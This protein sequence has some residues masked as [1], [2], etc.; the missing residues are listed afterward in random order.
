MFVILG[1][2]LFELL[3][4]GKANHAT[5]AVFALCFSLA[6]SVVWE[7]AEYSADLFLGMDMQDDTVVSSITSYLLGPERGVTGSIDSITSV[8]ID[9]IEPGYRAVLYDLDTREWREIG[10]AG[11]CDLGVTEHDFVVVMEKQ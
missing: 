3:S 7:F 8:V 11:S 10:C 6:V 9:G 4:H 2:Y 5:A 1:G